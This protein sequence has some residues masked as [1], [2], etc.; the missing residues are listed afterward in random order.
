MRVWLDVD[1]GIDDALALLLAQRSTELDLVGVSCVAGNGPV[2]DVVA[3][4]LKVLDAAGAREDLPVA[5]GF[6]RP[7][8]EPPHPCPA[9]HGSDCLGDLSPPLPRSMRRVSSSH[10]VDALLDALRA[11]AR[12]E[13]LAL[14]A[15]AP[16]TNIAA[17]LRRD[18]AACAAGLARVV[19]M[20]GAVFAGGNASAWGEA[21]AA[22]DPEAAHIVITTLAAL[23][24][25]LTMYPWDVYL[26]VAFSA[27]EARAVRGEAPW[28]RLARRLLRRDMAHWKSDSAQIG[29][30][31][32]I[33]YLIAPH[34]A[35]VRRMH[36]AV[37]LSG[38]ATRGMTVVDARGFAPPPPDAPMLPPNVDVI[39]DVDVD[40]L[41][42][43][44]ARAVFDDAP[45]AAAL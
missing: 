9:I 6:A 16:L 2:D 35:T 8:I 23:G 25:P 26:K 31:G 34:A 37:E 32:A 40:A 44:F 38:R 21:N 45:R 30:A 33:A 5:R 43:V 3:A 20:G 14:V 13:K 7:L 28:S 15:L 10:A 19:W 17:A 39:V 22:Y 29:D 42:R 27:A 36:V 11:A 4:T 18:P 41:K 24:V 12:S 1:T